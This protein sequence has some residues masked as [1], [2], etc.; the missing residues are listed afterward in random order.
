MRSNTAARS[1][2]SSRGCRRSRR[3][4]GDRC[5]PA[6]RERSASRSSCR[7]PSPGTWTRSRGPRSVAARSLSRRA[8][9]RS[10]PRRRPRWRA[11]SCRAS[12]SRLG[13][14]CRARCP[15]G[16]SGARDRPRGD[17]YACHLRSDVGRVRRGSTPSPRSPTRARLPR[18]MC[19]SRR[20][21]LRLTIERARTLARS[22]RVTPCRF[23]S[24]SPTSFTVS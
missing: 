16:V 9:I 10:A 1:P 14:A 22:R 15:R 18:R 7:E 6:A 21:S 17:R 5:R 2:R 4:A 13:S 3:G 12:A 19:T 11:P 8:A 24:V 20:A 23:D